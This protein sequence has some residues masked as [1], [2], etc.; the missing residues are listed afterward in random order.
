M[1]N[2]HYMHFTIIGKGYNENYIE[3]NRER[4]KKII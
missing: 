4:K 3:R 2:I 1:T